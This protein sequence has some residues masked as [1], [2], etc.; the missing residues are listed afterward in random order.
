MT[1]WITPAV[2]FAAGAI[3]LFTLRDTPD[4]P[5]EDPLGPFGLPRAIAVGL[6][7]VAAGLA[8]Q[9]WWGAA[10][11]PAEDEPPVDPRSRLL[12][13]LTMVATVAY[14]LILPVLGFVIASIVFGV[15]LLPVLGA[16]RLRTV[17]AVPAAVVAVLWLLFVY[18]LDVE[19]PSFL[20]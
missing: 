4:V 8:A 5:V 9:A 20:T 6:V 2:F 12:G 10:R 13:A 11:A 7:L 1:K 16:R 14:V 15:G 18:T 19:L 17:L 3:V